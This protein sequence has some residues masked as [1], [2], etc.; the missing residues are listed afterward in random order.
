MKIYQKF[1]SRHTTKKSHL[2]MIFPNKLK[3][4]FFLVKQKIY[5]NTPWS[6]GGWKTTF[7]EHQ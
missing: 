1:L 6:I 3:K 4:L 7:S 5:S 2:T